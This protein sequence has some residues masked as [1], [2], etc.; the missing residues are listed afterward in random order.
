MVEYQP[1]VRSAHSAQGPSP[2]RLTSK[3]C[4]A[5]SPQAAHGADRYFEDF[6]GAGRA[7]RAT[8]NK[9]SSGNDSILFTSASSIACKA[10]LCSASHRDR[11]RPDGIGTEQQKQ[12]KPSSD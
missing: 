1:S 7:T 4:L 10:C 2:P 9:A 3:S 12:R 6:G 5:Y 8:A 11:S